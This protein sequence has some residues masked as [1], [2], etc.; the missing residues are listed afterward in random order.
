MM[1]AITL[2]LLLGIGAFFV[3]LVRRSARGN[4]PEQDLIAEV[5]QSGA[6]SEDRDKTP[7]PPAGRGAR[8]DDQDHAPWEREGDWWKKEAGD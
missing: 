7:R 1:I 5:M 4:K 8:G 2:V 6:G 3:S